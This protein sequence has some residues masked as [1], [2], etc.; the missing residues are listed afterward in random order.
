M[1][2]MLNWTLSPP[3]QS[4][5]ND[6]LSSRSTSVLLKVVVC[7]FSALNRSGPLFIITKDTIN[8]CHCLCDENTKRNWSHIHLNPCESFISKG[9]IS[10][11]LFSGVQMLSQ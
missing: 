3:K 11:Y 8:V 7:A 6:T 4:K 5:M 1:L 10:K 2:Q 9:S